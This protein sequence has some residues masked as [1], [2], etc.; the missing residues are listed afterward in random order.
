MKN[1]QK[2]I[3]FVIALLFVGSF[4]SCSKTYDLRLN[5]LEK[6]L[7][8]LEQNYK[9]YTPEKLKSKIEE[10]EIRFDKLAQDKDK[11][12]IAQKQKLNELKREYYRI[13]LE[14]YWNLVKSD[15]SGTF[16]DVIEFLKDIL[17]DIL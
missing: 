14:I 3:V 5:T 1:K 16:T 10:C 15:I 6:S 17:D 12:S 2:T 7:N 13:L 11:M 4:N 8:R 9:S